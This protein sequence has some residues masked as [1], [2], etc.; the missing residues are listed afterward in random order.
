MELNYEPLNKEEILEIDRMSAGA[1]PK[2][3]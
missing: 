1:G 2:A 3:V